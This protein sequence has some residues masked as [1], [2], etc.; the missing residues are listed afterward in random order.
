M[1]T[2][3]LTRCQNIIFLLF[4]FDEQYH[5]QQEE[6]LPYY[7]YL[8][9]STKQFC[10]QYDSLNFSNHHIIYRK[11][12][13]FKIPFIFSILFEPKKISSMQF[14]G[15]TIR[16]KVS[17]ENHLHFLH[18]SFTRVININASMWLYRFVSVLCILKKD[19]HNDKNCRFFATIWFINLSPKIKHLQC[20][21]AIYGGVD[22]SPKDTVYFMLSNADL[23]NSFR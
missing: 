15:E 23:I 16:S 13:L 8:Q 3:Q 1:L 18:V 21:I 20:M 11:K 22:N 14:W 7:V 2:T 17:L 5:I 10:I 4:N 19:S 12:I 6:N 9:V